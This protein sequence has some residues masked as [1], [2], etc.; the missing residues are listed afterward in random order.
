M[1]KSNYEPG[2]YP[3]LSNEDYHADAAISAS[4]IKTFCTL[5]DL[6]YLTYLVEN[7]LERDTSPAMRSGSTA[8]VFLLEP[9]KFNQYFEIA[10]YEFYHEKNKKITVL[11]RRHDEYDVLTQQAA[12]KGKI[13]LL[14]SEFEQAQAMA[15][16]LKRDDFVY[17]VFSTPGHIEASFFADDPETGLRMRAKPD[18]LVEIPGKGIYIIDYKTS[19]RSLDDESQDTHAQDLMRHMQGSYHKKVI[20]LVLGQEIAG[21][22]YITQHTKP[23]FYVRAF[24]I[25]EGWLEVGTTINEH[26]LMRMKECY[27][28]GH[29][30]GWPK[31]IQY[32]GELKPWHRDRLPMGL[33]PEI[34]QYF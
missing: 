22:V 16:G 25:P 8:H 19:G 33:R 26:A 31:G 3:N 11:T 30:P 17:D 15:E 24:Q 23:P 9:D 2:F 5:P 6:Y 32:Y 14:S 13:L 29:F 10:P 12:E 21:V 1:I 7:K 34:Y 27:E 20:E 18:K 28:K 4:G